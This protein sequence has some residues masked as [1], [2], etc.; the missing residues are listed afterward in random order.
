MAEFK[1]C[2]QEQ[3]MLFPPHI[4]DLIPDNHLVRVV[5]EIVEQLDLSDITKK[6]VYQGSEAYH[7]KILVKVLFYGYS[8]GTLSSR[9]IADKLKTDITFMWLAAMQKPDFRTISDFRKQHRP[10]I[11]NLFIQISMLAAHMGLISMRH[12]SIDGSKIKANASKYKAMSRGRLKQEISKLENEIKK[13]LDLAEQTDRKEDSE[14]K[15][16]ENTL[17]SGL[18][19]KKER[20][21]KLEQALKDLNEQKPEEKAK[22]QKEADKQQINFIDKESRIMKSQHHGVQ[23]AYNAQIA[24]DEQVGL[25]IG[26]GLTNNP[27]DND[28]LIPL[29][30]HVEKTNGRLPDKITADTGYF[31]AENINFCNEK[32]LDAYIAQTPERKSKK[33][34]FNK[35]NFIYISEND[36]YVCPEGKKLEYAIT[37]TRNKG[38]K[39][40][41][42]HGVDCLKCPSQSKCVNHKSRTGVRHVYRTQNDPVKESMRSKVQSEEGK[43]IYSKRKCIVEPV[44]GQIKAIQKFRQFSFRGLEANTAEL[45]LVTIGHNLRKIFFSMFPREN[46]GLLCN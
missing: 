10:V 9:R 41:V 28:Q 5:S 29:L 3:G 15:P 43:K 1:P 14:D 34:P 25:I 13:L 45:F 17:P 33:N 40:R 16:D 21:A 37:K 42:Y 35:I 11:E 32:T 26:A 44:W 39:E 20:L 38:V 30:K 12:V 7:P 4:G 8:T 27:F 19:S 46:K 23:Q 22:N 24:V 18:S 2:I 31:T 6:Y 36:T